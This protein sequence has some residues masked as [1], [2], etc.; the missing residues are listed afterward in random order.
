MNILDIT[1][2]E[3]SSGHV[4]ARADVHFE[5]FTLKGFKILKD[6]ETNKEFVTPPSYKAGTIWRWL[7]KTDS[8]EDWKHIKQRIL[9]EYNAKQIEDSM[10][11]NNKP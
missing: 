7:F 9:D 10:K 1:F 6:E 11:V 5:G 3:S 4:I 2:L 8:L